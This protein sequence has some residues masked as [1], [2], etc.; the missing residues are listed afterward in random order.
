MPV[1][2]V[3]CSGY[4]TNLSVGIVVSSWHDD[5]T[6]SLLRGAIEA[7]TTR[8]VEE[9]RITVVWVP[10]SY[11]IPII[12]KAMANSG[13]YHALVALG[14]VIRGE[15]SHYDLIADSVNTGLSSIML[16]TGIPIGFGVLTVE[17]FE[18]AHERSGAESNKGA[19]AAIAAIE[20][21]SL[22]KKIV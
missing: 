10:G 17:N 16:E 7:L 4:E 6:S 1:K 22:L 2:E 21:V 12:T 8:S 5:I 11:E 14:C 13:H 9:D 3:R 15:T 18:Q 19:E 20:V